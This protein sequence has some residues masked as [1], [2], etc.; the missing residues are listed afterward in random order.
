[1]VNRGQFVFEP[2]VLLVP[3]LPCPFEGLAP[4]GLELRPAALTGDGHRPQL[5]PA[6]VAIR[7]VAVIV[8]VENKAD[9]LISTLTNRSHD[10]LDLAWEVGIDDEHEIAKLDPSLI[11][12]S[13]YGR[14]LRFAEVHTRGQF[15][16]RRFLR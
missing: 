4:L 11:A 15:G 7:V 12:A 8:R 16:D 13:E 10:R 6:H 2:R 14:C 3:V 1:K 5:A 9:G